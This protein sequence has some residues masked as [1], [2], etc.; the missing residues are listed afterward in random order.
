LYHNFKYS[1][2]KIF[3]MTETNS[4][5][6][7]NQIPKEDDTQ[8]QTGKVI[9]DQNA[10]EGL[11]KEVSVESYSLVAN[12][13]QVLKDLEFPADKRKVID[14]VKKSSSNSNEK[15]AIISALE[16]LEEKSYNNVSDITTSAGLVY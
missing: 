14:H 4:R 1:K 13:G 16:K 7:R 9:S 15:E 12:I 6:N 2:A 5:E 10:I 3:S 8:G 11:R